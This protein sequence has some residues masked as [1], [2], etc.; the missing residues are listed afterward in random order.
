MRK[1]VNIYAD[2]CANQGRV[3]GTALLEMALTWL[4]IYADGVKRLLFASDYPVFD[5]IRGLQDLGFARKNRFLPN[6]SD[7]IIT[8][9]EYQAITSMNCTKIL[10]DI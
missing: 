6:S 5:P 10:L 3:G 4:K 7:P 8:D 2:V 1:H 9:S